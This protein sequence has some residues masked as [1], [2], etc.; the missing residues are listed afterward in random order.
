MMA[1]QK[2]INKKKIKEKVARFDFFCAQE[3]TLQKFFQLLLQDMKSFYED[4]CSK[5]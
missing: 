4:S 1:K 5:F 2:K 3:V